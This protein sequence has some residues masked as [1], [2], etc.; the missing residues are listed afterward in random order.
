MEFRCWKVHGKED[1]KWRVFELFFEKEDG[2][3][4]TVRDR[5]GVYTLPH[6]FCKSADVEKLEDDLGKLIGVDCEVLFDEMGRLKKVRP[7]NY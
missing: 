6:I 5:S 3:P 2:M 4:Y 7:A 1:S